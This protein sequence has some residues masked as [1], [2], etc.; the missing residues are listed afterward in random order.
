MGKRQFRSARN[1]SLSRSSIASW[2][3]T[4]RSNVTR[5]FV[6]WFNARVLSPGVVHD[7]SQATEHPLQVVALDRRRCQ[8][9]MALDDLPERVDGLIGGKHQLFSSVMTVRHV[10]SRMAHAA[11][12]ADGGS[13]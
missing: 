7:G 10:A 3:V 4:Q 13:L 6:P 1:C 12:T 2:C 5:A 9:E 8:P 11:V